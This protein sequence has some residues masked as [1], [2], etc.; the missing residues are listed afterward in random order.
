MNRYAL[1]AL[2]AATALALTA[3]GGSTEPTGEERFVAEM[4]EAGVVPRVGTEEQLLSV[5]ETI[6]ADAD[7]GVTPAASMLDMA[8]RGIDA[9]TNTAV[10]IAAVAFLCPEHMQA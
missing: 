10:V 7:K 3:C 6:C 1:P 5:G 9:E 8:D 2:I 4:E